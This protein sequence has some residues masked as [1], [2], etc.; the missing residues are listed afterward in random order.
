MLA[1][2]HGILL[3]ANDAETCNLL[4]IKCNASAI[5]ANGNCECNFVD[6]NNKG[7][8]FINLSSVCK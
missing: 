7:I 1:A 3:D 4:C 5:F 2:I 6:D 8:T